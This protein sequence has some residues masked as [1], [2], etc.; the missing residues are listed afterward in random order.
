MQT[1]N[2][3]AA[4]AAAKASQRKPQT[5]AESLRALL[6][7]LQLRI[8]RLPEGR[9]ED[10][11]Q[12]PVMLDQAAAWLDDLHRAGGAASSEESLFETILAQFQKNRKVFLR[13]VGGAAALE[14]ARQEQQPT[15]DH[16]WWFVDQALAKERRQATRRTLIVGGLAVLVLAALVVVYRQFLAP[17][18]GLQ[19]SVGY[20][21]TAES[22][23]IEGKYEEALAQVILAIQGTPDNPTLYALQGVT[24]EMLEEPGLATQSFETAQKGYPNQDSFYAT[25]AGFYL[26]AGQ[27]E[28]A[29]ADT[30]AAIAIN[31][32]SAASFLRKAQAYEML[33]N[34][35]MAVKYY[36]LASDV[37]ARIGDPQLQ[38][39]ARMNLAQVM[40]VLPPTAETPTN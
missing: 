23:L 37:A 24:Y 17:D 11:M 16:W 14:K 31:P 6:N 36:E 28:Q 1:N 38:V 20:Q 21:N 5:L 18:P 30:E 7:D 2:S 9:T 8:I 29:L 15:A 12:I 27:G 34:P 13:R 40:Q 19:A 25:R 39:I 33:G 3:K 35:A 32:D 4:I 10:A 22:F 26:M